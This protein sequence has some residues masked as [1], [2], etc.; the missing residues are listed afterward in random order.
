MTKDLKPHYLPMI[1]YEFSPAVLLS[2]GLRAVYYSFLGENTVYNYQDPSRPTVE[3]IVG[4]TEIGKG[5]S[6]ATHTSLEPRLSL[7]YRFTESASVKLGYSRTAQFINQIFNTDSP[8]PNSQWQLST[9]YLDPN[10]SHNLSVGYFKNFRSNLWETSVEVYGRSIDNL[11]DY[12]DFADLVVNDHIETELLPGIGRSYGA[13]LSVKKKSGVINGWLSYTYSRSE[14]QIEGINDNQWYPSNFDKPHDVSLVLNYQPNRRNTL[15][16]NFNFSTGRPTTPPIGN[17]KIQNGLVVPIYATRNEYRIPDY[18]RLDVAYTLGKGYKRDKK[19]QTS[20]TISVYNL[21][22]RKNAF[23][24]FFTQ[25]AF[26][27]SQANK[28]AILG[29]AIPSLTFNLEIL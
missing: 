27:K 24:V 12:R 16:F 7:R 13:E 2:A 28:L 15:T 17:F 1:E 21:Y 22:A 19:I 29:S 14:L 10:R 18:H 11:Y 23:S 9:N 25:G 26:R 8:T 6:I 3:S 20:W 4:T 5:E